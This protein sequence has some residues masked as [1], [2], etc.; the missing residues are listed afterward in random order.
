LSPL[1]I[2][3]SAPVEKRKAALITPPNSQEL[4]IPRLVY[5]IGDSTSG[6]H[7][8]DSLILV[9]PASY[10]YTTQNIGTVFAH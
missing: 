5:A 4:F 1:L 6:P 9:C 3:M 7:F 8:L 2:I 10:F